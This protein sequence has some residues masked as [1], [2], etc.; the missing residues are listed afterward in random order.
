M[1][2]HHVFLDG[3]AL[4]SLIDIAESQRKRKGLLAPAAQ[5]NSS[6]PSIH[7]LQLDQTNKALFSCNLLYHASVCSHAQPYAMCSH[8]LKEPAVGEAV[9]LCSTSWRLAKTSRCT[10]Q[11]HQPTRCRAPALRVI[12]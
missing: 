3:C 9:H 11:D 1:P 7:G 12:S 4:V 2:T 10:G 5:V 8:D 6:P